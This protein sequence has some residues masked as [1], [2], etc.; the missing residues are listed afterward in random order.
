MEEVREQV[1]VWVEAVA[2]VE[3]AAIA[4]AQA[5]EEFVYALNAIYRYHI[6]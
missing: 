6:R 2:E 1:E 5:Q 4:L 3:W